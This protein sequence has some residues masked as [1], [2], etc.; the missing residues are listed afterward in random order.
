MTDAERKELIRALVT[1]L[2]LA[3][4]AVAGG[5]LPCS[6]A[7]HELMATLAFVIKFDLEMAA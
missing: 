6:P 2:A 4:T 3:E 7:M 5:V 1:A